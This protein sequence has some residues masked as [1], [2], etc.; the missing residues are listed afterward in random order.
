MPIPL[1][2]S[3]IICKNRRSVTPPID[4]PIGN[5]GIETTENVI[6]NNARTVEVD[7]DK[8]DNQE[9]IV[10]HIDGRKIIRKKKRK[11]V[12]CK[13]WLKTN[14]KSILHLEKFTRS[15][16]IKRITIQN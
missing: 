3:D 14:L 11:C 12:K 5:G 10:L 16:K 13:L 8:E 9:A 2:S 4:Y 15:V 6:V 1:K 7:K